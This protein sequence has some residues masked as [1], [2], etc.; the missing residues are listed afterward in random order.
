MNTSVILVVSNNQK[1]IV[2]SVVSVLEGTV[3]PEN[4]CIVFNNTT[5]DNQWETSKAFF[6]SCCGGGYDEEYTNDATI[7]TKKDYG[8]TL[9]GIKL[10]KL[11]DQELKNYAVNYLYDNTDI[12]FTLSAGSEYKPNFIERSLEYLKDNMIG[13]CYSDYIENQ[14]YICLSSMKIGLDHQ[15]PVKEFG[16]K[17]ALAA[18]TPFKT[19]NFNLLTELYTKSVIRHIPEALF[20]V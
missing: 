2:Q 20:V 10:N 4:L 12:F 1:N 11:F 6:R 13:G 16:F 14:K 9:T 19:D 18:R 7:I 3:K 17:K 8:L 5:T 15:V